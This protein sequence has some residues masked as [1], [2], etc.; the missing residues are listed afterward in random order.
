MFLLDTNV[1]SELRKAGSGRADPHVVS[2]ANGQSVTSLFISSITILEIEMGILQL[3]RK[4]PRQAA[5]FSTWLE[6]HVLSAF[7]SRV[8][9]FDTAS[10]LRCAQLHVPDPKSER[11]AMIAATALVH[12]LTL[13]TGNI[14]DFQHINI[15]LL[16]PW[17][18]ES[19]SR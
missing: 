9:A 16:D 10:A 7:A 13:V 1:L 8:L 14:K 6:S 4:D 2:W 17:H 18:E 11:D 3:Q 12:D 15:R 19:K 5:V